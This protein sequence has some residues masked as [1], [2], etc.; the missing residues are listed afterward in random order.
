AISSVFLLLFVQLLAELVPAVRHPSNNY[1]VTTAF[2][3]DEQERDRHA[4]SAG[5]CASRSRDARGRSVRRRAAPRT[6]PRPRATPAGLALK[7]ASLA[8]NAIEGSPANRRQIAR[9]QGTWSRHS[10]LIFSCSAYQLFLRFSVR[11]RSRGKSGGC[12]DTPYQLAS[13]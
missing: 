4:A 6:L 7:A 9:C 13:G 5:P 3:G 2:E 11:E 8:I 12:P 10:L 1:D